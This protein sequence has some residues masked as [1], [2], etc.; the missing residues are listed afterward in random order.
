M[1]QNASPDL[2]KIVNRDINPLLC[3]L[4][5][6][7]SAYRPE[8]V[9][10]VLEIISAFKDSDVVVLDA[11][12]GSGKTL[13][14][15]TVRLL[16]RSRGLYLC[17]SKGLQDQFANDFRYARVVKGRVNYPTELYPRR[18]P[19]LS[20]DDCTWKVENDNGCEWC[21]EKRHCP[22]ELAKHAALKADV[23]VLNFAYALTELN[24][25]G[26]FSGRDLVIVDEADL[27]E[28]A[29]QDY[30]SVW[31]SRRRMKKYGWEPPKITVEDSW[32]EWLDE[33]IP[34]VKRMVSETQDEKENK[35]LVRLHDGL[36][37]VQQAM[38]DG[39]PFAFTGREGAVE[40]KPV[41]IGEFCSENVWNHG[42][43]WLLMS[44][45][46][47][48]SS[49]MLRGLGYTKSY[50]T[51]KL[52]STFPLANRKVVVKP[53]VSMA[54]KVEGQPRENRVEQ[55]A[56]G[57]FEQVKLEPGRI[58]VHT[59]SHDL[60]RDVSRLLSVSTDRPVS[61]YTLAGE[62]AR[63]ISEWQRSSSGIL[64]A[65]STDRGFD[66]ADDACRLVII[67]KVPYPNLGD[68]MIAKRVYGMK[69]QVWYNVQT[70]RTI[71]QMSGRG[72][73]HKE[74]YCK[75]VILDSQFK[76]S[77]WQSSRHLIPSWFKEAIVWDK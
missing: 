55:L 34:D 19:Q 5:E 4:P 46:V 15:E 30:I 45:T 67:A 44:A 14:G 10:A 2:S 58:L 43:K 13:I 61:C 68:R 69:D 53:T 28:K 9:R 29:V 64:V 7:I 59:V 16:R 3:R 20:A 38:V 76:D 37:K 75:T 50:R 62:R 72:V 8:Q 56:K 40:F 74:D 51:V 39:L 6:K 18:F 57:I 54:R 73:R 17:H 26:R 33:H 60:T 36:S 12:T 42:T 27:F 49:T 23:A 11:P 71:V 66:F 21:S 24:G 41:H 22:Y 77:V 1:T 32:K 47:I 52:D 65:A 48:S 70:I 31:V 25:P 35:S 63:A